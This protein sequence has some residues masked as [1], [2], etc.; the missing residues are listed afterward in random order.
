MQFP[1]SMDLMNNQEVWIADT[2]A[3]NHL[4]LTPCKLVDAI[5]ERPSEVLAQVEIIKPVAPTYE[6][7]SV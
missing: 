6:I 1:V 2:G 5:S 7:D 4:T 3:S